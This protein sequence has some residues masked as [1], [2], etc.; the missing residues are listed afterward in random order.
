MTHAILPQIESFLSGFHLYIPQKL[1]QMFDEYELVRNTLD[2]VGIEIGLKFC[3]SKWVPHYCWIKTLKE[4]ALATLW[5][6]LSY[7]VAKDLIPL[8]FEYYMK[9]SS[10]KG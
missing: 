1:V 7:S 10:E 9:V 8:P 6:R 3:V 4:E 5:C 2:G